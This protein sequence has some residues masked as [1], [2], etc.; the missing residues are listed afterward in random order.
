MSFGVDATSQPYENENAAWF[1]LTTLCWPI[2]YFIAWKCTTDTN[3][4]K[5]ETVV[6]PV[7]M[8]KE[9]AATDVNDLS[10]VPASE[11]GS[12]QDFEKV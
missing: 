8:R 7:H 12:K 5:E 3:Y 1:A 11:S 2:L 9:L 10:P 4:M 6:T